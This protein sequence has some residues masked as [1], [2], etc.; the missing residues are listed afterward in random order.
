MRP[1]SKQENINIFSENTV[2]HRT[3]IHTIKR[4]ILRE[5]FQD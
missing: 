5:E 1:I 3:E 2:C 4:I